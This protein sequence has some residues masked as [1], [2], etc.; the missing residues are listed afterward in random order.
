MKNKN[1][2]FVSSDI[3]DFFSKNRVSFEGFY[4]SEKE[5]LSLIDWH[6]D[7]SVLDVGC[8]CGGLG[9][10]LNE[11]FGVLKYSGLDI[12]PG[13]I[14]LAKSL[15]PCEEFHFYNTDI[16]DF[17][18]EQLYDLVVSFSCVDWNVM[19]WDMIS[20]CWD[21]VRPG[22]RFI[23]TFRLGTKLEVEGSTDSDSYQYI[24]YDSKKEGEIAPYVV[25][26]YEDLFELAQKMNVESMR[27]SGYFKSPSVTAV[28]PYKDLFFCCVCFEKTLVQKEAK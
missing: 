12:H 25:L 5:I 4:D 20:K 7:I 18:P 22:G 15:K 6:Q 16:L 14:Q 10:A 9:I 3:P 24:N 26:T 19:T 28:T 8:G 21:M 23:V 17:C 2:Q 27:L 1:V 11:E 13:A